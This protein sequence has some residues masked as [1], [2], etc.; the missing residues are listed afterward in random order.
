MSAPEWE[1]AL[2]EKVV[3]DDAQMFRRRWSRAKGDGEAALE[4]MWDMQR[5][6]PTPSCVAALVT[7]REFR[8]RVRREVG[9]EVWAEM[10]AAGDAEIARRRRAR[11]RCDR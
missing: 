5:M 2:L 10:D 1:A 11:A 3:K 8:D 7:V 4:I 9:P 6:L